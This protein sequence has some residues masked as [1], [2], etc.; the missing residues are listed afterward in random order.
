MS[1]W[2][3]LVDGHL[4]KH[5]MV[6]Q[7]CWRVGFTLSHCVYLPLSCSPLAPF[8]P[9]TGHQTSGLVALRVSRSLMPPPSS[10]Q[11]DSYGLPFLPEK[12]ISCGLPDPDTVRQALNDLALF[13]G[14][15]HCDSLVAHLPAPSLLKSGGGLSWR[16]WTSPG[17]PANVSQSSGCNHTFSKRI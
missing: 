1:L 17:S 7:A 14:S 4:A 2:L 5:S 11:S 10:C 16:L 12:I 9:P 3:Q 15:Q 8:A 6:P 13:V